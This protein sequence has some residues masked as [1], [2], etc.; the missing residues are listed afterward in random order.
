MLEASRCLDQHLQ[1]EKMMAKKKGSEPGVER[2]NR[3]KP[4]FTYQ[5]KDARIVA[6]I[7][8]VI[9]RQRVP[10]YRTHVVRQAIIEFLKR[11]GE[12]PYPDHV[13]PLDGDETS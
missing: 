4:H 2:L 3:T 1:R 5:V 7:D 8:R 13:E 6:G 12:W 9:R 10:T 11:E